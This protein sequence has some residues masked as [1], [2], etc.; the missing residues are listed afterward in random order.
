M[1]PILG[2]EEL[3][4]LSSKK[5]YAI[6]D[7]EVRK[8]EE[9]IYNRENELI[10]SD[11]WKINGF[12]ESFNAL[13]YVYKKN[14]TENFN[15]ADCD[16]LYFWLGNVVYN[17]LINKN[18]FYTVL[19]RFKFF[20]KSYEG[21]RRCNFDKYNLTDKEFKDVMTLFDYS[22]DYFD[23]QR[24]LYKYKWYCNSDYKALIDKYVEAYKTLKETCTGNGTLHSYCK[25]FYN[26]FNST[27]NFLISTLSCAVVEK[28]DAIEQ[29]EEQQ[30]K[31]IQENSE[32]YKYMIA[33][34][35]I[36]EYAISGS[37]SASSPS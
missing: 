1:R 25:N 34:G 13:C 30:R 19:D 4:A 35:E 20:L 36:F 10:Y 21:R 24:D 6:F 9:D 17:N 31:W 29:L 8:C 28:D 2:T 5:K 16:Y 26:F 15:T 23:L 7:K 11:N 37:S 3:N 12:D 18:T 14:K 27:Q 32:K 22:K 33:N